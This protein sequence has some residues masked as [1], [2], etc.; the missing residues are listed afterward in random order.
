MGGYGRPGRGEVG[1]GVVVGPEGVE[2]ELEHGQGGC[3]WLLGPETLQA[4]VEAVNFAE[5]LCVVGVECLKK[6]PSPPPSYM[7]RVRRED[8]VSRRARCGPSIAPLT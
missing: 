6:I 1:G 5:G 8:P 4:L 3:C 7:T 2:L